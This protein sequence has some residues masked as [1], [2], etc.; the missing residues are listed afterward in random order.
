MSVPSI[1]PSADETIYIVEDDFGRK[2]GRVYRETDSARCDR[3]TTLQDLSTGQYNDP[4]RV[5]AFNTGEGW[6]RDVSHEFAEELQRRADFDR[7]ELEGTLAEF[8][9]YYTQTA[10]Q[11]SLKL[12]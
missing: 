11:L 12:A 8:V 7:V 6:A 5:V 10:R 3:E 4:V 1:V 2:L 9:E